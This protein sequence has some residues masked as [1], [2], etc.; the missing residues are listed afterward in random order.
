MAQTISAQRGSTSISTNTDTTLF[1]NSASGSSRVIINSVGLFMPSGSG[2]TNLIASGL[3]IQNTGGGVMIPFALARTTMSSQ[4]CHIYVPGTTPV[5]SA[6]GASNPGQII[7][8]N[9]GSPVSTNPNQMQWN[10]SGS[11]TTNNYA[12]CP[13]SVWM[14]PSDLLRFRQTNNA[15]SDMT[16]VYNFTVITET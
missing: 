4:Y 16:L 9:N 15:G 2:D 13:K 1:T 12:Y 5:G 10:Y 11:S 8:I 7:F 14:G 3:Y 6:I